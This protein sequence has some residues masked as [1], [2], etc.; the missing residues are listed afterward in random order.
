M[1]LGAQLVP[2]FSTAELGVDQG[3]SSH[4]VP[5]LTV[6]AMVLNT[7]YAPLAG[8]FIVLLIS[9]YLWLVRRAPVN[10]VAFALVASS[11]WVASEFFKTIIARHRPDPAMLLDPLSPETGSNSFPSGHVAFAVALA[12]ALY[13]L[14][15]GSRWATG[16]AVTGAVMAVVVAWS[17]VY[18]GVHYP[19]DVAASFPAAIAA[20]ILLAGLWNRYAAR[21]MNRHPFT[22]APSMSRS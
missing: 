8:G 15:R 2:G 16:T 22:A 7:L 6:I 21:W 13:F 9:A 3:L 12:F 11:G 10:A 14:A 5:A 4:H 19:S 20:E 18:I 1:G 17:R